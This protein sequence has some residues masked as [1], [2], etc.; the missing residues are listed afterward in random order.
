M[1]GS[2][3]GET[4]TSEAST[5]DIRRLPAGRTASVSVVAACR[6]QHPPREWSRQAVSNNAGCKFSITPSC[7]TTALSV[8]KTTFG[9]S[10]FR[11]PQA[12]IIDHVVAAMTRW[13]SMP[14]GGVAVTAIRSRRC[15]EVA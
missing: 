9:Y 6:G 7:S 4:A 2:R 12:D 3:N 1:S 11:G 10:S 14:T 5:E 13:Y 8:L 15:C